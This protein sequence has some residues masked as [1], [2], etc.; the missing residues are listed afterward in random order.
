MMANLQRLILNAEK[1]ISWTKMGTWI[2]AIA[3]FLLARHVL[4]ADYNVWL[5]LVMTLGGVTG[6][7]GVRDALDPTTPSQQPPAQTPVAK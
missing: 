7:L 1:E 3:G 6:A 2:V 4:P 5:E